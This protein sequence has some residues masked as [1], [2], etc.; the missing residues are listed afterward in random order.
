LNVVDADVVAE[1][2][3]VLA[4]S[5]SMGVPVKPM[6]DALGRASR[7]F[8]AK[9]SIMSYWLRCASS[10]MTT[11][12]RRSDSIVGPAPPSLGHELLDRGEDHAAAGDLQQLAQ[13]RPRLSACT[14]VWRRIAWHSG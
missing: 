12:L 8:R 5:F 4:S 6:N 3:P 7:R 11:I 10:A 2:G 9:P 13:V 14:G 1:D